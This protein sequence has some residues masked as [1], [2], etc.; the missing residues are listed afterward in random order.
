MEGLS[1]KADMLGRGRIMITALDYY[2]SDRVKELTGDQQ[3]PATAK[4]KTIVDFPV[5][6]RR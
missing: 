2:I 3:T 4:P 5:A 6:L 1:G